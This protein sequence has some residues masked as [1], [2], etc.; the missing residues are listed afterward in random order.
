MGNPDLNLTMHALWRHSS[1]PLIA[2]M[3]ITD[4]KHKK[5]LKHQVAEAMWKVH[6]VPLIR[7]KQ[8]QDDIQYWNKE[9][10]FYNHKKLGSYYNMKDFAIGFSL[11]TLGE[12]SA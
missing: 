4:F 11:Q 5:N 7:W 6:Q 8:V 1:L 2:G 10:K 12:N 3:E 9:S